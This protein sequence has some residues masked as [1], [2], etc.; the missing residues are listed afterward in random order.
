[1]LDADRA[2]HQVLDQGAVRNQIRNIWGDRVFQED[3]K[4]DRKQLGR[5]VFE[6]LNGPKELDRLEEITHPLIRGLLERQVQELKASGQFPVAILDAPVM[7]KAGWDRFC[8]SIIFVE[9]SKANRLQRARE[10]GWTDEE[11]ERREAAQVSIE[12][13]KARSDWTVQ[14]DGSLEETKHQV[15][16]IWQE[17]MAGSSRAD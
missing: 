16:L 10:R 9:T 3:G 14:N 11:F 13:K 5:I 1:M 7:F 17:L 15:S 4:V 8:D 12:S 2:G 6:P